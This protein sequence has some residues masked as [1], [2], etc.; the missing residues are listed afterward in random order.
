M[1]LPNPKMKDF[2]IEHKAE[3]LRVMNLPEPAKGM[4]KEQRA[5]AENAKKFCGFSEKTSLTSIYDS[6]L[7]RFY[8]P[9]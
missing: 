1:N 4:S 7:K 8:N 6:I 2:V 3:I 5:L 9:N